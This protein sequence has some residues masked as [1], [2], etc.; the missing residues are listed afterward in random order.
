MLRAALISSLIAAGLSAAEQAR[1]LKARWAEALGSP[2]SAGFAGAPTSELV[3]SFETPDFK[4]QLFRQ[5]TGPET[6]QRILLLKPLRLEGRT[7]GVVVPFYDPDRM[8]GYDLRTKQRLG[9]ER[10]TAFFGLHLVRLGYVVA[11]VEAYPFNLLTPDER[12]A[13]KGGMGV[14][15]D[16]AAK[17]ARQHPQWTGMGKLT[18]DTRLAADLLAADAQVDPARLAVMGHSL[19]GKMAFYAGCLDPRFKAIVASD[20]GLAWDSSNWGD[21]WYFGDQLKAMRADGLSQEQLLAVYAPPFFLIAGQYDS[22]ATS[23]PLLDAA[24]KTRE[25]TGQ[26]GGIEMFDHHSGHQPTWPSLKAAY[27][28]LA[29]R[30]DMPAP[31]FAHLDVL[32]HEQAKSAK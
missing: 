21:A 26:A 20:F 24:R 30:M 31:D 32:A 19:G 3:E 16:A 10:N 6:W 7:A 29:Q 25:L 27:V 13:S 23:G 28:W 4:A 14:W 2:A 9:P 5:R 12:A 22:K 15:R 1:P 18:H 11:A 8:C 17:L